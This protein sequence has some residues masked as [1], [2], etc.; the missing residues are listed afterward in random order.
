MGLVGRENSGKKRLRSKNKER[1]PIGTNHT[2]SHGLKM[3][4]RYPEVRR[5]G[6]W[7]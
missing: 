4:V 5:G 2:V 1:K 3:K 6:E 7:V